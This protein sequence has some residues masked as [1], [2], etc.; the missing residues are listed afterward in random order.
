[1]TW[2][3][4]ARRAGEASGPDDVLEAD[5]WFVAGQPL[6]ASD[7]TSPPPY[8]A[9]VDAALALVAEGLPGCSMI[10]TQDVGVN[11][12]TL[13]PGDGIEVEA[14]GATMPLS[15]LNAFCLAMAAKAGEREPT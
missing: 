15:L 14:A 5:V 7:T 1:M 12:A 2:T 8:T 6:L 13:L 10:L 11:L 4:L 3:D 9:S